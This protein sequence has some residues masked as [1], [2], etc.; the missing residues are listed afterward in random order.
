M[1]DDLYGEGPLTYEQAQRNY[2]ATTA[3]GILRN[4]EKAQPFSVGG[5]AAAAVQDVV[6]LAEYIVSGEVY[7]VKVA[8]RTTHPMVGL[9]LAESP[10]YGGDKED[11]D[12]QNANDDDLGFD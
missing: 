1:L 3:G 5:S 8:E 10:E 6:D 4:K 11:A 9:L 12:L 7:S 2:A